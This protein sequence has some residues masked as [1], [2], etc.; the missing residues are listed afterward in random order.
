VIEQVIL[1]RHGET[2][3]NAAGIAQ[4][5]NDSALSELGERQVRAVAR[6]LHVFGADAL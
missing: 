3:Q 1:I 5:W 6:R 2:V 4:G